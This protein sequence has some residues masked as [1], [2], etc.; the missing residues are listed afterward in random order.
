MDADTLVG[1]IWIDEHWFRAGP[2]LVHQQDRYFL[3]HV[4]APVID[5]SGLDH[6]ETDS[7]VEHRWWAVDELDTT[8][9]LV[10]PRGLGALLRELARDGPPEKAHMLKR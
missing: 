6:F 8:D 4:E 3:L 9:Q 7:M 1:P 10:Y 2:D 5:V